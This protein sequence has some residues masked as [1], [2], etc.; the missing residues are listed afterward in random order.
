ML[1]TRMSFCV[2]GMQVQATMLSKTIANIVIAIDGKP[3]GNG[4]LFAIEGNVAYIGVRTLRVAG[5]V[6][7]KIGWK[8]SVQ[9]NT[10]KPKWKATTNSGFSCHLI[11][12][13]SGCIKESDK[14]EL[15]IFM[16]DRIRNITNLVD[17]T[18]VDTTTSAEE[19]PVNAGIDMTHTFARAL[20]TF[21]LMVQLG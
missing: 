5:T 20:A 8:I 1:V 2:L 18:D 7:L 19:S 14:Q 6:T 12:T 16:H 15:P 13:V 4:G 3:N 17:G 9:I 10:K 11:D 21:V